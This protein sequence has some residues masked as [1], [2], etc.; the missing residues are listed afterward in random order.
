M[1]EITFDGT[2]FETGDRIDV[3]GET[4]TGGPIDFENA[5]ITDIG[6]FLGREVFDIR[7]THGSTMQVAREFVEHIERAD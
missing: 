3:F 1:S 7:T 6:E 2:T 5:E 4:N